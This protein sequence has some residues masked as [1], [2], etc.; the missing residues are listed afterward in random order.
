VDFNKKRYWR[1]RHDLPAPVRYVMTGET[2]G[3]AFGEMEAMLSVRLSDAK[4]AFPGVF[5]FP[6]EIGIWFS[7]TD[8]LSL[9]VPF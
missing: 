8:I 2:Y 9:P 5:V 7:Y 4:G 1:S 3:E 6:S